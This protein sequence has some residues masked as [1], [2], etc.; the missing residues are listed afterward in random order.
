MSVLTTAAGEFFFC[1]CFLY[2]WL[3]A[4]VLIVNLLL[5]LFH[6]LDL[7][8]C[9]LEACSSNSSWYMW[10]RN[11]TEPEEGRTLKFIFSTGLEDE[12]FEMLEELSYLY[13]AN[14]KV[15][16]HSQR[17]LKGN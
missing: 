6:S 9:F 17:Q 16:P 4:S 15:S 8:A 3:K 13:L 14:N 2:L 10:W 11:V 12:C 1:S 7:A 5:L